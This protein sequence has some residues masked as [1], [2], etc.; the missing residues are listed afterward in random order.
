MLIQAKEKLKINNFSNCFFIGDKDSDIEAG[1]AA[2]CKTILIKGIYKNGN[3]NPDYTAEDLYDA[4][5][6]IVL[7]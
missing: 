7:K 2:G 5:V 1:K 6:R 3:S 4:I